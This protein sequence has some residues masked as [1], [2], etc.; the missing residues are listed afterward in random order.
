MRMMIH[1]KE[2]TTL[3]RRE[4]FLP[5]NHTMNEGVDHP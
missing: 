1:P 2:N 4:L 5:E 3:R